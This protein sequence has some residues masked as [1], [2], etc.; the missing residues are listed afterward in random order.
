MTSTG[1]GTLIAP[2]DGSR[3]ELAAAAVNVLQ[4][5]GLRVASGTGWEDVDA[6]VSGG[7]FVAASLVTTDHPQGWVQLRVRRGLRW[8][9]AVAALVVFGIAAFINPL[10]A[11]ALAVGALAET[12][13]G[14]WRTG[15]VA[16]RALTNAAAA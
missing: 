9:A 6:W 7:L 15:A 8:R 16:H 3:T 11:V 10:I 12:C 2:Y 1:R 5:A 14:L 13:R 4:L